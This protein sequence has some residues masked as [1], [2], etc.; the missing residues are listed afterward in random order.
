MDGTKYSVKKI[1][2][3]SHDKKSGEYSIDEY[4]TY[5][6]GIRYKFPGYKLGPNNIVVRDSDR[7]IDLD[8]HMSFL[9]SKK[10]EDLLYYQKNR[11]DLFDG[12]SKFL[13]GSPVNAI[14]YT[15][16]PRSG[17]TFLRKYLENITGVATGSD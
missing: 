10:Q 4:F 16:Y 7:A 8:H 11:V 1:Q 3:I 12:Q 13:K 6:S 17:N 2:T 5:S 14:S 15:S 9:A